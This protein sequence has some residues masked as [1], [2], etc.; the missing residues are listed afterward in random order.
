MCFTI[1]A[2]LLA[3]AVFVTALACRAGD[4]PE[5]QIF[6]RLS[7]KRLQ[8]F[9]DKENIPFER[10]VIKNGGKDFVYHH[11]TMG[12]WNGL[13]VMADGALQ[14][15]ASFKDRNN[16]DITLER[17]NEWNIKKRFSRAFVD[18]RGFG[19]IQCD[20]DMFAGTN[21]RIVRSWLR[22][23]RTS[24]DDFAKFTR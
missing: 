22:V 17:I 20:L 11:V 16:N 15:E 3:A 5:E 24:V 7:E 10:K 13:I 1:R 19:V 8:Q 21:E 12:Q 18:N 9:L 14:F 6:T 2:C 23:C 4:T